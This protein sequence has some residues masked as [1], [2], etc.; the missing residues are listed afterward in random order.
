MRANILTMVL[1]RDSKGSVNNIINM[2]SRTIPRTTY[3]E[4][5][6]SNVVLEPD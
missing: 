2:S 1:R 3:E 5:S 4:D 6:G